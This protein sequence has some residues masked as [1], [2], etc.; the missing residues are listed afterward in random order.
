M[1][2]KTPASIERMPMPRRCNSFVHARV[3][4]SGGLRVRVPLEETKKLQAGDQ[5]H[6]ATCRK[7]LFHAVT[8]WEVWWQCIYLS[9]CTCMGPATWAWTDCMSEFTHCIIYMSHKCGLHY[10]DASFLPLSHTVKT[11]P[12]L[13]W[14]WP[15]GWMVKMM[16]HNYE[17]VQIA[18]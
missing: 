15:C 12:A 8:M 14:F 16:R 5:P 13:I 2:A 4:H 17:H 6:V 18:V 9:H 3:L 10:C 1:P 7:A 11:I